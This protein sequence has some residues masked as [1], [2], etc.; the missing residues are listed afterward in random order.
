M[1]ILST[2]TLLLALVSSSFATTLNLDT[3][4]SLILQPGGS[5]DFIFSFTNTSGAITSNFLAWTMG[6]QVVPQAGATGSVTLGTLSQSNTD[7]MPIGTTDTTQPT[8]LTL[9]ASGI[10]NGSTLYY[11]IAMV[12]TEALGTVPGGASLNMGNLGF[13]AVSGASGTW[14]VYA[15]QQ[16]AP[17]Y[18]SYWTDGS[19]TDTDFGNL[20]RVAG[21]SSL[22]LGTVSVNSV[23][24]EPASYA[25]ITGAALLG[26]VGLRRQRRRTS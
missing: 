14:N 7:P 16:G 21:N 6:I 23:I 25:A 26:M 24:P 18:Q 11:Q 17:F 4:K 1:K 2:I 22:L 15:I 10:I 19:L 8:L 3:G 20:P 9:G 13:N 12:T 5:G